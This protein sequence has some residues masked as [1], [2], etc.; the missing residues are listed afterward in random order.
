MLS[1]IAEN[2]TIFRKR[3]LKSNVKNSFCD[4]IINVYNNV[5]NIKDS[6]HEK[7]QWAEAPIKTT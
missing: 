7:E 6:D 5:R 4:I 3:I 1:N 2:N